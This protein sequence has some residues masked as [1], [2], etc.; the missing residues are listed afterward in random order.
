M[1]H[2]NVTR[3]VSTD[4]GVYGQIICHREVVHVRDDG[5]PS[6][7]PSLPLLVLC[8]FRE[9]LPEILPFGRR[10]PLCQ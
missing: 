9:P 3:K 10:L 1:S 4:V 5:T 2:T 7:S 8:L 6:P